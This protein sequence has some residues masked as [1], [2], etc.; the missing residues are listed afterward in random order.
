MKQLE[1]NKRNGLKVNRKGEAEKIDVL[2]S[3]D[4]TQLKKK[5]RFEEFMVMDEEENRFSCL[6]AKPMPP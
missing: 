4:E 1:R 6:L 5:N 2:S 3:Y